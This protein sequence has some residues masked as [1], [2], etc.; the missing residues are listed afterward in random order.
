MPDPENVERMRVALRIDHSGSMVPI[1]AAAEAER[2][3][4]EA[5]QAAM[6]ERQKETVMVAEAENVDR[7]R[8]VTPEQI[9][10]Q[11][12]LGWPD[13]HPE[14]FCHRCGRPNMH[15]WTDAD[16]WVLATRNLER[17][18]VAILC[19]SCFGELWAAESGLPMRHWHIT[20]DGEAMTGRGV[21][22]DE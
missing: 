19:P 21:A 8:G 16:E 10:A 14:D 5:V 11:R 6:S 12:S 3:V 15:W 9:V 2:M 20:P 17:G 13:F 22:A 7:M 1:R 18:V 4:K